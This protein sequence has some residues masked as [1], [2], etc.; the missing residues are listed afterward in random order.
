MAGR[1]TDADRNREL[2]RWL[3]LVG[4]VV[5]DP[6]PVH[7]HD[8]TGAVGQPLREDGLLQATYARELL[9]ARLL[10]TRLA[11]ATQAS[12]PWACDASVYDAAQ[13]A[14]GRCLLVGDAASFIEPLS[15]AGVK[16]ALLSAWRAA[17]VTNTCLTS[18]TLTGA[19]TELYATR[20]REV[21]ADCMRRSQA[22]FAEAAAAHGTAFWRRR[23]DYTVTGGAATTRATKRSLA[24]RGQARLR[25]T[26]R[27]RA[28]AAAAGGGAH[29][30][31]ASPPSRDVRS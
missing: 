16:K 18:D 7:R 21:F 17:V 25:A 2:R 15:S 23:A 11:G 19:A 8:R 27:G 4:A 12:A 9:P 10:S 30:T 3:G 5:P 13:A 28:R 31:S 1:R 14:D 6:S 22:F 26:A 24:T 29:A 20:E